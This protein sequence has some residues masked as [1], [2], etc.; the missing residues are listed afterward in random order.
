MF[1]VTLCNY[2]N[3]GKRVQNTGRAK[4]DVKELL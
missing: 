1:N 2:V 4:F 3:S